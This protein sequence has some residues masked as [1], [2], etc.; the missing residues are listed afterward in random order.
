MN[1]P[2]AYFISKFPS[3]PHTFI[4]REVAALREQGQSIVLFAIRKA[5]SSELLDAFDRAD[6]Q[7]TTALLPGSLL[8]FLTAHLFFLIKDPCNYFATLSAALR[9]RF[10]V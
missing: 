7:E 10:R 4:R 8:A 6:A 5:T 3:R 2:I 1:Q 9:N